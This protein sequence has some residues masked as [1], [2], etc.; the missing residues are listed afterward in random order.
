MGLVIAQ[1]IYANHEN[2]PLWLIP[3]EAVFIG[4]FPPV[5]LLRIWRPG[6]VTK[7]DLIEAAAYCI[8]ALVLFLIGIGGIEEL[9]RMT[10]TRFANIGYVGGVGL[11]FFAGSLC[12]VLRV[13]VYWALGRADLQSLD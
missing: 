11:L 9:P 10:M 6:K 3:I 12:I 13:V 7:R 5:S 8:V 2:Y 1:G 4:I